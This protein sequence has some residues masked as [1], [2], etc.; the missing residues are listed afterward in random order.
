M[1]ERT[2]SA[3]LAMIEDFLDAQGAAP[4]P[5]PLIPDLELQ[6][7]A[8]AVM[9]C[10]VRADHRSAADEHRVLE[11]AIGHTLGLDPADAARIVRA[12]EER[13]GEEASFREFL[14]LINAGC[15]HDEKKR[16]VESLWRIAFADA[17]LQSHE[18][19]LV[20]KVA[21]HLDLSPADLVETK[22]R[23]RET[24]LREDI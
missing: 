11:R 3:L 12:A 19:Y 16:V 20:R 21:E 7:A 23:A 17:E 14:E 15:E 1:D 22:I 13:L 9:V 6:M 8:V 10:V 18:E 4:R 5:R 24:F 2:R